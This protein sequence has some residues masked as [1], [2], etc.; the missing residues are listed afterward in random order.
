M[1]TTAQLL[2]TGW[3]S[4]AISRA[5]ASGALIRLHHG[6]YAAGHDQL[7][8]QARRL[9]AVLAC[10]EGAALSFHEAAAH[11]GLSSYAPRV[12]D[13]SV[14]GNRRR[15]EGIRVHRTAFLAGDVIDADGIRT[16]S[17]TRTTIDLAAVLSADR[18]ENVVAAAERRDLID[19]AR[20]EQARSPELRQILGLGPQLAR[21][22]DERRLQRAIRTA[23]LPEPQLN[24]WLTHGGGEQWQPDAVW[25]RERVIVEVDDPSH[26]T[27][28]AFEED[29]R[30]D[31][32]RQADGWATIRITRRQLREDPARAIAPLARLLMSRN[33]RSAEVS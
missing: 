4:A 28:R 9:A 16:T 32:V 7:L 29:R 33:L 22:G 3:S 10:G 8:R 31:A 6:V 18:L 14:P 1:I 15:R 20:V 25:H 21:S 5:V 11:L 30:K 24:L 19:L 26:R 13:V 27:R 12:I 17:A 23:G 2:A